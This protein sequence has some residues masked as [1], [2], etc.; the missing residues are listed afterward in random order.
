MPK[1]VVRWQII[2]PEP[3]KVANFYQKLFAWELSNANAMGYCEL[4]SGDSVLEGGVW[5]APQVEQSFVQLFIEVPDIDTCIKKAE[6][7][8][9]QVLVP[10][11]VLPDGDVMAVLKDPTGLSFGICHLGGRSNHRKVSRSLKR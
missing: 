11:S 9:A 2:S 1:P 8:G 4:G 3:E 5:P 7:L 6:K 10:K